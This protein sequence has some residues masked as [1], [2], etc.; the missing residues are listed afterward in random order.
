MSETTENN[1]RMRYTK[2]V[3]RHL[4]NAEDSVAEAVELEMFSCKP[5]KLRE[6]AIL[7]ALLKTD[8]WAEYKGERDTI[9]NGEGWSTQTELD[10]EK[11]DRIYHLQEEYYNKIGTGW[12]EQTRGANFREPIRMSKLVDKEI[13]ELIE[14]YQISCKVFGTEDTDDIKKGLRGLNNENKHRST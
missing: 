5:L 13:H 8:L 12:K 11:F 6:K 3:R 14:I 9:L 1:K 4:D 2:N 10:E 7:G